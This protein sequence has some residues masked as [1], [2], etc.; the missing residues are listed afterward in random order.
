M[1]LRLLS[2]ADIA[3]ALP[4]SRCIEV[5]KRAFADYSKGHAK[6]PLRTVIPIER[7]GRRLGTVL[8]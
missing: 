5:M 6:V 4:M 8:V 1:K 2:G 3:V 7:D